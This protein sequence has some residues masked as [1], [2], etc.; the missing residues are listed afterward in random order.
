[1]DLVATMLV[2]ELNTRHQGSFVASLLRPRFVR[3]FSGAGVGGE[4]KPLFNADRLLNRFIDYPR[5]VRARRSEFDLFHIVDHSYSHLATAAGPERC[6]VTCHDLDTFRCIVEPQRGARSI[7]YTAMVRRILR[8]FRSA[9]AI[10]CVSG[11]TRD[12]VLRYCIAPAERLTVNPNGVADVFTTRPDPYAEA[13]VRRLLGPPDREKVEI[14]H[15]GS[16][17]PRK[18]IDVL[19][20]V[21]AALRRVMPSV[22][23]IRVGGAFRPSQRKLINDLALP[24]D[25]VGVLPFVSPE[26]LAAVYRRAVIT[27]LPSESEGFGLP[28]LESLAC[29]TPV[30]LSD[31]PALQEIGGPSA[32]FC[33]VADVERWTEAILGLIE[34]RRTKPQTWAE[35]AAVGA[36]WASRF[37]WKDYADRAVQLYKVVA[38]SH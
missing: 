34:E 37:T 27:L 15:V 23:I 8:G 19:I 16:T 12:Q 4:K 30:V 11:A 2:G 38:P 13:E 28:V 21:A 6:L 17:I 25:A 1:M 35:R 33:P 5:F 7:P 31:I 36:Q 18:R 26:M 22:R 20:R 24:G 10:A 32:T 9:E 29:G 3:R 14:T